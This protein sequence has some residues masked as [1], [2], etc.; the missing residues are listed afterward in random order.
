MRFSVPFSA[1]ALSLLGAFSMSYA[2][3]AEATSSLNVGADVPFSCKMVTPPNL[4]DVGIYSP[5]H[6]EQA[7][8]RYMFEFQC[9]YSTGEVGPIA[10][11]RLSE[12]L[13]A[14]P[15]SSCE[16]PRRRMRSENGEYLEYHVRLATREFGCGAGTLDVPFSLPEGMAFTPMMRFGNDYYTDNPANLG[17]RQVGG[18]VIIPPHQDVGIGTYTDTMLL[19][20]DF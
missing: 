10:T 5:T 1:L 12:G 20:V 17:Q 6:D 16:A 11:V 4:V 2:H 18:R 3:A 9:T 8:V 7:A 14:A 13:H 19:T 15:G